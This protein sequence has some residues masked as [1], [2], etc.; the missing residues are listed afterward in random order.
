MK[1]FREI[2]SKL[3]KV[4][5][6]EIRDDDFSLAIDMGDDTFAVI[7]VTSSK[8]MFDPDRQV[9]EA[10]ASGVKHGIGDG[11]GHAGQ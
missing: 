2:P 4:L 11:R 6:D 3:P 10:T 7:E 9:A 8:Q 5:R 1:E